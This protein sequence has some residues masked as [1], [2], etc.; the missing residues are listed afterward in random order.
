MRASSRYADSVRGLRQAHP[1]QVP[2]ERPGE[3]VARGLRPLFRLSR[4]LNRQ[5]LLQGGK[6]L[7]Q[8]RLFQVSTDPSSSLFVLDVR[9]DPKRS[10]NNR[11]SSR[12]RLHRE[13]ERMREGCR[14]RGGEPTGLIL[15]EN[16]KVAQFSICVIPVQELTTNEFILKLTRK[17]KKNN[18]FI[19]F[20]SVHFRFTNFRSVFQQKPTKRS[21]EQ[22]AQNSMESTQKR[23]YS[24]RVAF[25]IDEFSNLEIK[26]M[27]IQIVNFAI[28]RRFRS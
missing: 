9:A 23:M 14:A 20:R 22:E 7:L 25:S 16:D 24:F 2:A 5:V 8:E 19:C 17:V 28:V 11:I 27:F 13:I 18:R 12:R 6:A 1:G 3:D 21:R 15:K 4:P 26:T 10:R